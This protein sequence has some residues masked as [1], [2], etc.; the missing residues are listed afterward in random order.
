ME[1]VV[2]SDIPQVEFGM[3]ALA[4]ITDPGAL[5]SA[6]RPLVGQYRTWLNGQQASAQQLSSQK[7]R[8]TA[9]H[10]VNEARA[11][12]DRID[13]G[14]A[15]LETNTE[16]FR[17]FILANHCMAEAASRRL[18]EVPRDQIKWRPF[19]LAFILLNLPGLVDPQNEQRRFVELLFFPTG[20]GKT[21]A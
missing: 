17:A 14:I 4:R 1:R 16:A 12:A 8:N 9:I 13:Q 11:A 19:Q 10:L 3:D 21:E 5:G 6:L 7:R 15:L 2:A 18:K 20:G